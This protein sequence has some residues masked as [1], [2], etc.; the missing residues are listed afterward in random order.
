M[1]KGAAAAEP[2]EACRLRVLQRVAA[3]DG[4]AAGTLASK[5]CSPL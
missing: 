3:I 5:Q 1:R 4:A 2:L